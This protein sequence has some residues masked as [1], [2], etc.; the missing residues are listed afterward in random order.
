MSA[1]KK[2][3]LQ[4]PDVYMLWSF[5]QT[6][7]NNTIEINTRTKTLICD[8]TDADISQATGKFGAKLIDEPG[9]K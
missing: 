1:S 8:C 9:C 7:T 5:A 6:L 4:F 2:I 3:V